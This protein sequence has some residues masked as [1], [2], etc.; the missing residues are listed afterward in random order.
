ML[1]A[2]YERGITADLF[3]GTSVGALNAAFVASRPQTPAT[4][5][6]LARVWRSIDRVD[7]FPFSLRA[8][9]GGICGRTDHLVTTRGLRPIIRRNVQIDDVA[10]CRV[11]LHVVAFDIAA[12]EETLIS[13]GPAVDAI[14]A[15]CAIPGVFPPVAIGDKLLIDGGVVNNT[16]IRHAV[17][18]GAER[19]YVLPTQ[20]RPFPVAAPPRTAID[21]ALHAVGLL[22]GSRLEADLARYGNDVELIVLPAV[23]PLCVQPSDFDHSAR[24][25]SEAFTASREALAQPDVARWTLA[26]VSAA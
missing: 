3:V 15:S 2:L 26:S 1:R 23:N 13:R 5:G 25:A 14:V 10:D 19:I 17:E 22:M 9:F 20:D 12:G 7:V 21:A 6:E 24:L 18:L 16:P 11:P 4:V 8:V